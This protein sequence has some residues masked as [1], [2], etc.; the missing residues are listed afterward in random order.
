MFTSA[1]TLRNA[2][3]VP[4]QNSEIVVDRYCLRASASV[5]ADQRRVRSAQATR[6]LTQPQQHRLQHHREG[7]CDELKDT[8]GGPPDSLILQETKAQHASDEA[9]LERILAALGYAHYFC[10]Y[11][12]RCRSTLVSPSQARPSCVHLL[13]HAATEHGIPL[14]IHVL[15]CSVTDLLAP[16]VCGNL[17]HHAIQ[18]RA[19]FDDAVIP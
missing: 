12:V 16:I 8:S 18:R 11:Q 7:F 9:P 4:Q 14:A 5:Q 1:Y 3:V 17:V 19:D 6:P 10:Q 13:G 2:D 15:G